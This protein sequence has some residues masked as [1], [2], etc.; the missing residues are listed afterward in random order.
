MSDRMSEKQPLSQDEL[1]FLDELEQSDP[2]NHAETGSAWRIMIIDD[3]PRRSF[4]HH[5]RAQ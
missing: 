2:K 5:L 1:V 4:G 3:D